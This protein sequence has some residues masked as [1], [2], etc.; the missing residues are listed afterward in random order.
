MNK[1]IEDYVQGLTSEMTYM[2]HIKKVKAGS[3]LLRIA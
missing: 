2:Y 3:P 1:R